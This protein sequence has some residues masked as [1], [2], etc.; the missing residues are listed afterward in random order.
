MAL[1]KVVAPTYELELPSNGKK[2][3]Y[4]P[5]LVKEEKVLLIAM[6]SGDEKQITQATV[7]VIKS[8][9]TSRL[10]VEDLPS[11]DLEYLFLKI[12]AASVGEEITINVV[13][14]D[15]NKTKVQH[16]ININ[17][18]E[19][20]RPKGHNEKVMIN[21]TVGVI[22]KYPKLDH[23]ID[24]GVRGETNM[25][26]LDIIVGCIDQIFDGEDVTESSDCTTK[27][28]KEFIESL[29]QRQFNKV[30]KFFETMPKLQH[31]FEVVNPN[32][33]KSSTYTLEGLQSFFA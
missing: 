25:D 16:T 3:K 26:G 2:I 19:V 17:D 14:M 22:M 18:V 31:K 11:F 8:C 15:D 32:T 10:K 33:K 4:R 30:S 23:F 9:V 1:P 20:F 12:R 7:D 21:K 13:C 29:T 27:E 24:F 28:L 5:F 6:D